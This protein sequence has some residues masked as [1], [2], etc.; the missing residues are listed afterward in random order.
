MT[1]QDLSRRRWIGG[2]VGLGVTVAAGVAGYAVAANSPAADEGPPGSEYAPPAG[3]AAAALAALDAVPD[4]GGLILKERQ[5]VLTRVGA[6]V[7]C[8]SAVCTHQ[9]CLVTSVADGTI[10]CPCH[11]S[12]FDVSHRRRGRRA[13]AVTAAGGCGDRDERT[14]GAVMTTSQPPGGWRPQ[15]PYVPPP[16]GPVQRPQAPPTGWQPHA[17]PQPAGRPAGPPPQGPPV[18]QPIAPVPQPWPPNVNPDETV[19]LRFD[20]QQPPPQRPTTAPGTTAPG[21]TAPGTTAPGPTAATG[22]GLRV[23]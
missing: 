5:L 2:A 1:D 17:D 11:G 14:G 16:G 22:A 6:E 10:N 20:P 15:G 18:A 13:R 8:F 19:Q 9:Q 23:R 3:P 7:H 4:G 12:K 21:T